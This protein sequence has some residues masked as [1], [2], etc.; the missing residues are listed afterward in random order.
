M[1]IE[2]HREKLKELSAR[3]IK[4]KENG[5]YELQG[6]GLLYIDDKDDAY[7][8][9]AAHVLDA[10]PQDD[11]LVVVE[12]FSQAELP[13]DVYVAEDYLFRVKRADVWSDHKGVVPADGKFKADDVAVIP[14]SKAENPK[15]RWLDKRARASFLDKDELMEKR[16]VMGFGYPK[17]TEERRIESACDPI[18]TNV[19][20]D[21]H[22]KHEHSV[23]WK[24]DSKLS[25]NAR[26]GL[27]GSAIALCDAQNVVLAAIIQD[28]YPK[29]DGNR[30]VGTDL[31][32]I[33]E[34]LNDHEVFV[35]PVEHDQERNTS[36]QL[37]KIN[38]KLKLLEKNNTERGTLGKELDPDVKDLMKRVL[39]EV[40]GLK[41][42]MNV[43][44][45]M[46]CVDENG[47]CAFR[48]VASIS[49]KHKPENIRNAFV[50]EKLHGK[51]PRLMVLTLQTKASVAQISQK[52][53]FTIQKDDVWDGSRLLREI[54]NLDREKIA[55]ISQDLDLKK[56]V[57][58]RVEYQP[59]HWLRKVPDNSEYFELKSRETEMEDLKKLVRDSQHT[60]AIFISGVGGI[61][62]TDLA[63]YLANSWYPDNPKYFLNYMI[64]THAE[65]QNGMGGMK[66][67]ILNV[68]VSN[69]TQEILSQDDEY[70]MKVDYLLD[71]LKEAVLIVDNF[72]WPGKTLDELWDEK[73]Y[74][75]EKCDEED[76]NEEKYEERI[77]Q[78]LI[79]HCAL[80]IFTT[81][82]STENRTGI[83]VGSI[84]EASL[85]T[86]INK[87][88]ST[89]SKSNISE[90]SE[91][92]DGHTLAVEL[93]AKTMKN[94]WKKIDPEKLRKM[95]RE[96]TED[97]RK[98]PKVKRE[99][100][101]N[102]TTE[103]KK[104]H[105]HLHGLFALNS[106]TPEETKIMSGAMLM[107]KNGMD[108]SAFLDIMESIDQDVEDWVD[109]VYRLI[110]MGWLIRE[111]DV[112]CMNPMI[113]IVC[114]RVL[115]F[116]PV[117]CEKFLDGIRE[118]REGL[119]AD[120]EVQ[121]VL[122]ECFDQAALWG[123]ESLKTEEWKKM[124][125]QIRSEYTGRKQEVGV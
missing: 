35:R 118:Y 90:L 12:C 29:N 108:G 18:G 37:G 25:V 9:T 38:D 120:S 91:L 68:H 116:D 22:N 58:S 10:F 49:G 17:Y 107:N 125:D 14:L 115:K 54:W 62:K 3:I 122:A 114:R 66:K 101:Y 47:K 51:Y 50:G 34:I 16:G 93:M 15:R 7:I 57:I 46:D 55:R 85:I 4:E 56:T 117:F 43:K 45:G 36:I 21:V 70:I 106:L 41:L 60:K 52:S 73:L 11:D 123:R 99:Y 119:G 97:I 63:I 32:R 94:S 59:V 13:K 27:S 76:Y 28:T 42:E 48:I 19:V 61:G 121:L 83:T 6:S 53:G 100:R 95:I 110:E 74:H 92:V 109:R 89:V 44:P 111:E 20:Y 26:H 33:R 102:G 71:K 39:N 86:L 75:K 81:R 72:D 103:N 84:N 124:A 113:A 64:P 69:H 1:L 104:L 40:L 31:N 67:T 77:C 5:K 78:K 2:V 88:C 105:E 23:E 96:G 80:V 8:L 98:Y 112:I 87:R 24:L 79:D 82:C 30:I 65:A